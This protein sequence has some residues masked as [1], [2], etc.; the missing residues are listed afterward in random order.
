MRVFLELQGVVGARDRQLQDTQDGV[1]SLELRQFRAG[2]AA[3]GDD[4]LVHASSLGR[5]EGPQVI[6]NDRQ[7]EH[8]RLRGALPDRLFGE[9]LRREARQHRLTVLGGLHY[10][11]ER[12]LV[13]RTAAALA[14]RA[15]A[16]EVGVVDLH[17]PGELARV[18]AQPHDLQQLVLD[19]PCRGVRRAQVAFELERRNV[20]L[21]LCE[22]VHSEEPTGQ[23]QLRRLEDRSSDDAALVA[24]LG[25]VPVQPALSPKRATRGTATRRAGEALRPVRGDQRRLRLR[26]GPLLLHELGHRQSSLML[27][28]VHRHGSPPIVVNPSFRLT[29]S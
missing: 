1:D 7:R 14:V 28:A 6:G 17:A 19:E 27:H 11:N 26:L 15:L 18:F 23:R 8:Q 21:G 29:G 12:H 4:T 24:A 3:A 2:L 10:R 22:Q 25:A 5:G 16:A 20:V 13:L 9:R